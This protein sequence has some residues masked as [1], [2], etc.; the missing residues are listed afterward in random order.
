MLQQFTSME[1]N[2]MK[3]KLSLKLLVFLIIMGAS[4]IISSSNQAKS[5]GKTQ[6][7]LPTGEWSFN[8]APYQGYGYKTRDVVVTSVMTTDSRKGLTITKVGL[9]NRSGKPVSSLKLH[10]VLFREQDRNSVLAEGDTP[11]IPLSDDIPANGKRILEYPVVSFWKIS[12]PLQTD[13]A[14]YG[15]FRLEVGVTEIQSD[16]MSAVQRPHDFAKS[17]ADGRVYGKIS[18]APKAAQVGDACAKKPS[19]NF[20]YQQ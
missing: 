16:E 12:R 8:A 11:L 7:K 18:A 3:K 10:W 9:K 4:L 20:K 6:T 5:Q 19:Q 2:Q 14:L 17:L 1:V 15:S 13:G